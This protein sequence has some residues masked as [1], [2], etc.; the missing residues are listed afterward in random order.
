M[1]GIQK[2]QIGILSPWTFDTEADEFD[3]RP[4]IEKLAMDEQIYLSIRHPT[5]GQFFRG[6]KNYNT[7]RRPREYHH[8]QDKIRRSKQKDRRFWELSTDRPERTED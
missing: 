4:E 2:F 7:S 3:G 6:R 8:H 5:L 1:G